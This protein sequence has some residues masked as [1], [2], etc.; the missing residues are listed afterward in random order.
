MKGVIAKKE[1]NK[2]YSYKRMFKCLSKYKEVRI[3]EGED[4]QDVT[5]LKY[6]EEMVEKLDV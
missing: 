1:I 4:W 2:H 3:K 5:M 6:V